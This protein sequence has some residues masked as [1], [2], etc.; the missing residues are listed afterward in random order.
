MPNS[1]FAMAVYVYRGIHFRATIV[2][3]ED[4]KVV[5]CI[6]MHVHIFNKF[7]VAPNPVNASSIEVSTTND[8]ISITWKVCQ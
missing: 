7:S 1:L 3:Y 6:Y 5:W 4:L 8:N 2:A